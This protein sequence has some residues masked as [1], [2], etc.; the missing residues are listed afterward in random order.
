MD[1]FALS[2]PKGK[3]L[4]MRGMI[5]IR[6]LENGMVVHGK[7]YVTV[8]SQPILYAKSAKRIES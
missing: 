2:M 7:E 1:A 6:K 5:A 8:T 4:D 3:L